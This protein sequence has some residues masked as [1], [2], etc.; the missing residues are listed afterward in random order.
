[1][2]DESFFDILSHMFP[3]LALEVLEFGLPCSDLK[4]GFT[5]KTLLSTLDTGLANLRSVGFAEEF[6][7]EQRLEEDEE[8]DD[9]LQERNKRRGSQPD[10]EGQDEEEEAGVYYT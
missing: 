1:M 8:I 9:I 3:P 2:V 5:T 6:V 7:T 10:A 4:L